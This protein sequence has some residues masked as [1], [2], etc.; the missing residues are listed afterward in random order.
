ALV[1]IPF[2]WSLMSFM[3]GLLV[4]FTRSCPLETS[5]VLTLIICIFGYGIS[6][7]LFV[8]L[9]AF[10]FRM[11]RSNRYI[12]SLTFILVNFVAFMSSDRHVVLYYICMLIPVFPPV[13]W[14]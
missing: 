3:F 8:Y 9:M 12:W 13:G 5:T 7:V 4:L 1:D 2:F 11:A 10:K 14:I 6:L